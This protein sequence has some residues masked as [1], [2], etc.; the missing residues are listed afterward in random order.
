[1]KN[2]VSYA[3]HYRAAGPRQTNFMLALRSYSK[4]HIQENFY[5]IDIKYKNT[6]SETCIAVSFSSHTMQN[7][8]HIVVCIC[9]YGKYHLIV[10]LFGLINLG[11]VF[12]PSKVKNELEETTGFKF[13]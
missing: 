7:I 11:P 12:E 8:N 2:P 9:K 13:S 5:I 10:N 1:M 4:L 6:K 3:E